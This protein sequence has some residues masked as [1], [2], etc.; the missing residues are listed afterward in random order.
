[1]A[2]LFRRLTARKDARVVL[3]SPGGGYYYICRLMLFSFVQLSCWFGGDDI[4][5]CVIV[6]VSHQ[7]VDAEWR[8][9]Q[10]MYG[11]PL[12]EPILGANWERL[13]RSRRC[14]PIVLDMTL[15]F[16]SVGESTKNTPPYLIIL[17]VRNTRAPLDPDLSSSALQ[18][19]NRHS[20]PGN[21]TNAA[22]QAPADNSRQRSRLRRLRRTK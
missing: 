5:F 17:R 1:M 12:C 10:N 9:I 19:F 21:P 16:V 14:R 4:V 11:A 8:E 15:D 13:L 18:R 7:Q 22:A 6:V 20:A 2:Q 3:S